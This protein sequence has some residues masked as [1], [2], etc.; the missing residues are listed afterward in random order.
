MQ[1]RSEISQEKREQN[2]QIYV[3]PQLTLLI[4]L[5]DM[6]RLFGH[7][8]IFALFPFFFTYDFLPRSSITEQANVEMNSKAPEETG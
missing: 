8:I 6:T 3:Q 2:I 4:T 5:K 7:L 1:G